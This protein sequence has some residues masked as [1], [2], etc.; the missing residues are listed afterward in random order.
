[1]NMPADIDLIY[2]CKYAQVT[3][4]GCECPYNTKEL[5]SSNYFST[6]NCPNDI[7]KRSEVGS[8]ICYL[9]R[10]IDMDNFANAISRMRYRGI[11]LDTGRYIHGYPFIREVGDEKIGYIMQEDPNDNGVVDL[12]R[13]EV[14][15]IKQSTLVRD[16]YDN[17]IYEG[18]HVDYQT[19]DGRSLTGV[20]I[21]HKGMYGFRTTIE[22]KEYFAPI[23]GAKNMVIR[24]GEI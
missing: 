15:S 13:V 14:T 11:A 5:L 21:Y 9:A 3:N 16:M 23:G 6:P 24:K 4:D 20:T 2:L 18:D 22:G 10:R 7:G 17:K 1:M 8:G 12:I 19:D